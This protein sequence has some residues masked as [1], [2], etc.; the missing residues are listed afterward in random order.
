MVILPRRVLPQPK[1]AISPGG[2]CAAC[3]LGGL[4]GFLS[5]QEVYEKFSSGL[6]RGTTWSEARDRLYEAKAEGLIDR[7]VTDVPVWP[8]EWQ[9][10][11]TWGLPGWSMSLEW[12]AYMTMAFDAGYYG[13]T[14]ISHKG[15]GPVTHTDHSVLLCG[16][17]EREEP[18]I[19]E[20]K[21]LA[22]KIIQ[23]LLVSCSSKGDYW[24]E[25][26][27]FLERSGGFNVLL[28]RPV[29]QKES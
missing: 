1:P 13:L 3:S 6:A 21:K 26:N 12:F 18:V 14:S 17:R 25:V 27:E 28:A 16:V 5:V 15:L 8:P 20:G 19:V 7:L 24:V 10:K 23:E 11:M 2:D 29:S 9:A 4:L 22:N